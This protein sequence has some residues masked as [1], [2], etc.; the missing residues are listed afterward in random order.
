MGKHAVIII[1][2]AGAG[3]STLCHAMQ[4][5][6]QASGR[7]VHV[8]N[9]D[10]AA[11]DLRYQPSMD[12]RDLISVDDAMESQNLGPNGG[13]VFCMEY[14]IQ[15]ASWL[16]DSLGDYSDDFVII[17]MPGQIEL[18][19]HIPVVPTF[20]EMLKQEGY[21]CGVVFLLDVLTATADAGKF[22]SGCLLSLSSMVSIDC[23]FVNVLSK[24]DL[25]AN[26]LSD[27]DLEHFCMCDFDYL[28]L[29]QLPG[30]WQDMT[31]TLCGVIND[32]SLVKFHPMDV[33]NDD[34]VK[35]L[36]SILDE[37]TQV[38]DDAE[39]RDRDVPLGEEGG[40]EGVPDGTEGYF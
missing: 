12:V 40:G 36:A 35:N 16:H 19:S 33:T 18:I 13:L 29:Q 7:T 30:H 17:D 1:G 34:N 20:I 28:K 3:K 37:L 26:Q 27:K 2:P 4:E 32:F 11:E 24:C 23:P 10:P 5:F 6:Y 25:I 21:M 31:R 9:F 22:V 38:A 14:L 39:V 8:C 15:N